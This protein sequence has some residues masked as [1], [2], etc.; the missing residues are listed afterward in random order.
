[1][2][3]GTRATTQ[4]ISYPSEPLEYLPAPLYVRW[5]NYDHDPIDGQPIKINEF[6]EACT[7]S[8]IAEDGEKS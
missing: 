1:M 7:D 4:P 6:F 3:G 2:P 8:P 5:E